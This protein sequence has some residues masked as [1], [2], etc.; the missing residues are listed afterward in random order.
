M[1]IFF[2]SGR[3]KKKIMLKQECLLILS[4]L[5]EQRAFEPFMCLGLLSISN[6]IAFMIDLLIYLIFY[7][8]F[9]QADFFSSETRIP[10]DFVWS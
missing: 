10:V 9:F 3:F 6:K 1:L 4:G 7:F 2:I 8:Y 5:N